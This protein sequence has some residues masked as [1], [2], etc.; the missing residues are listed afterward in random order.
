MSCSGASAFC[1]ISHSFASAYFI[2]ATRLV[3]SPNDNNIFAVNVRIGAYWYSEGESMVNVELE[4]SKV[5]Q[6]CISLDTNSFVVCIEMNLV[7]QRLEM[8]IRLLFKPTKLLVK[9]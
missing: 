3:K 4:L 6:K 9:R 5:S 2:Y 1:C 8:I 7:L